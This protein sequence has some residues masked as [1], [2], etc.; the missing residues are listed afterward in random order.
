MG[1]KRL[2][3]LK[4]REVLRLHFDAHL[5]NRQIEDC[6]R[7]SKTTVQRC[8][9]R[10]SR[11]GLSWPL[12]DDMD[13]SALRQ[14]MYPEL[15]MREGKPQPDWE[16]I[17]KEMSRKHVTAQLL[18]EEYRDTMEDGL[19]RSQFYECYNR[20]RKTH[21][22]PVFRLVHKGGEKLFIDFSGD[23]LSYVDR[24]TGEI[25]SVVLFV[26]SWGASSYSFAEAAMDR[27]LPN[28]IRLNRRMLRFFACVPGL[29]VPDNEKTAAIEA[30]K[31]EPV[32]HPTYAAFGEHYDTVILPTRPNKPRDK[33]VVESNV[34]H[35]QR[36]IL[37]RLRDRTF[38]SLAEIN[39]AIQEL[40][41]EF[42]ERPMQQ[43]KESRRARFE[44]LDK[45][46]AKPLPA[47]DFPY[48]VIKIDVLVANDYHIEYGKHFYSVPHVLCGSRVEVRQTDQ[49][50]EIFHG[51]ERVAS[52]CVGTKRYGRTTVTEHMP[53]D[54]QFVK[55]WS[56]EYFLDRARMI[57]PNTTELF[58]SI[59][60][61]AS[62]KEVSYRCLMGMLNLQKTYPIERLE[63]AAARATYFRQK[64]VRVLKSILEKG[65]DK[66]P[67]PNGGEKLVLQ[68]P[69]FH[70]NIRGAEYY[71]DRRA[72]I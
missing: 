69:L 44:E 59:M 45:P 70:E 58:T 40:L 20:F 14:R 61:A 3:V 13:D 52:H 19:G 46:F 49:V 39:E 71:D 26:A 67:L 72:A 64:T 27:T 33:A 23:G 41:V 15:S 16:M 56:P 65:L 38:F 37:G 4:I 42:N 1:K 66:E 7:V 32:V 9:E 25:A 43:Y 2:T 8:L 24:S 68:L 21:A 30:D 51:Q 35:I 29:I 55:G 63:N 17:H 31:Y 62:H 10:L 11:T 6:Q 5:S 47:E 22:E 53:K 48:V 28:W 12:P 36:F 18:W 54:H 50:V 34:L 57:G 60:A